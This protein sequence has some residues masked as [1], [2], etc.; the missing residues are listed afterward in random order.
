MI[1][2]PSDRELALMGQINTGWST[3]GFKLSA[4]LR[5]Q[6][7]M[8][9]RVIP[10][11]EASMQPLSE[12][13]Q[14]HIAGVVR[15]AEVDEKLDF[16]RIKDLYKQHNMLCSN[17]IEDDEI[18][19]CSK[20]GNKPRNAV[21]CAVCQKW[22]CRKC[23][24]G[25][26]VDACHICCNRRKLWMATGAWFIQRFDVPIDVRIK[27][28]L[29]HKLMINKTTLS[30][31][32]CNARRRQLHKIVA[33]SM[34]ERSKRLQHLLKRS[35]GFDMTVMKK[36]SLPTGF[37][38]TQELSE[39]LSSND[40]DQ[41][42]TFKLSG[43]SLY[44]RRSSST[45]RLIHPP[46]TTVTHSVIRRY[47]SASAADCGN[48]R[49][50]NRFLSTELPMSS[51]NSLAV[52][53][54][55]RNS[56]DAD[57]E[58][59][60]SFTDAR[61]L[62]RLNTVSMESIYTDSFRAQSASPTNQLH[63]PLSDNDKY[64]SDDGATPNAKE[65]HQKRRYSLSSLRYYSVTEPDEGPTLE[66]HIKYMPNEA[67]LRVHI[68]RCTGLHEVSN[69]YVKM[70]IMSGPGKC[71]KLKTSIV[72]KSSKPEFDELHT[73]TGLS[74]VVI[75]KRTLFLV[76]VNHSRLGVNKQVGA[77]K[78][79]LRKSRPNEEIFFRKLLES[80][81][82]TPKWMWSSELANR[83]RIY[84]GMEYC[85]TRKAL[86]VEIIEVAGLLSYK[87]DSPNP[88]V[89][90]YLITGQ[91]STGGQLKRKTRVVYKT[92]DPIFNEEI[93]LPVRH[94]ELHMKNLH[95]SVWDWNQ[96]TRNINMGEVWIN[97]CD[98]SWEQIIDTADL[99]IR[100]WYNLTSP[101]S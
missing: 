89:K 9:P 101:S 29:M 37:G 79:P 30:Q 78:V 60:G 16:L 35:E 3:L 7:F 12:D 22:Y 32:K 4:R 64:L 47:S 81:L 21:T 26:P 8:Q 62:Q 34:E 56:S 28:T 73:F 20:C 27:D 38:S 59:L 80:S 10:R 51:C 63:L 91:R 76:V 54:L 41:A 23:N 24:T 74:P 11:H 61:H 50:H 44:R 52:H 67:E 48:I 6:Q 53:R 33:T 15:R 55:S 5:D 75:N 77:T 14:S 84:L 46:S 92:T 43:L 99:R 82:P 68:L 93:E 40:Q 87:S 98:Q 90:C 85:S 100:T 86:V 36:H 97:D 72:H 66:F 49:A 71:K 88:Y 57:I 18:Q 42:D 94:N 45:G 19:L 1:Q 58:S 2:Y 65:T 95:I 17:H 39:L 25:Y 96:T 69:V 83:G 31:A 13:E 70:Y